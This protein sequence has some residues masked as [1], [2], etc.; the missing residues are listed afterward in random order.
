MR[1]RNS[2][3]QYNIYPDGSIISFFLSYISLWSNKY[4][5]E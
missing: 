2:Q 4:E 5:R 1:E 3:L